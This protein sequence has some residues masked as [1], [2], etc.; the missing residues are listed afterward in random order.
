MLPRKPYAATGFVV[1]DPAG[2]VQYVGHD[3]E[4]LLSTLADLR[5]APAA[6]PGSRCRPRDQ[7]AMTIGVPSG[8]WRA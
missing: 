3:V 1:L 4:E 6:P 8:R 2:A 5:T 7:L